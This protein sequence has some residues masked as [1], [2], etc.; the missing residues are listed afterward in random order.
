MKIPI[1]FVET[2]PEEIH[3]VCVYTRKQAVAAGWL[4]DVTKA[5]REAGIAV[6]TFITRAV[7][8]MFVAI[9][10]GGNG[11]DEAQR[12]RNLLWATRNMLQRTGPCLD[13]LIGHNHIRKLVKLIAVCSPL[14]LDDRQPAMTLMLGEEY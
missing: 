4:I 9:P 6:P 3:P 12:L 13:P 5:A 7:F 10:E 1:H 11:Q 2:P 14:E 8:E